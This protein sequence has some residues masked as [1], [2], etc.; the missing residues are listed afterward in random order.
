EQGARAAPRGP[1]GRLGPAGGGD[2]RPQRP[3]ERGPA[4]AGPAPGDRAPGPAPPPALDPPY[5]GAAGRH[6]AAAARRGRADL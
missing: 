2:R 5:Q 4:A 1:G 3:P 6:R